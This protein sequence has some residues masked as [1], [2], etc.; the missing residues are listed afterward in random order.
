MFSAYRPCSFFDEPIITSHGIIFGLETNGSYITGQ[1]PSFIQA[2]YI[3][4]NDVPI[5]QHINFD[6]N[7]RYISTNNIT[8]KMIGGT[9]NNPQTTQ[10]NQPTQPAIANSKPDIY[11]ERRQEIALEIAVMK[12]TGLDTK[13]AKDKKE[14]DE[15][16]SKIRELV[17]IAKTEGIEKV[18]YKYIPVSPIGPPPPVK[19]APK[20]AVS[21][22]SS[23]SSSVSR[24]ATSSANSSATSSAT[25]L[26]SVSSGTSVISRDSLKSL[27]KHSL[28]SRIARLA[29][30]FDE[31]SVDFDVVTE[32]ETETDITTN[33]SETSTVTN[34]V[35]KTD[36]HS[37]LIAN[38]SQKQIN[39]AG[40]V[41]IYTDKKGK[42]SLYLGKNSDNLY[43]CIFDEILS[44][45][46]GEKESPIVTATKSVTT[47]FPNTHVIINYD[48]KYT[49]VE[50]EDCKIRSYLIETNK[51]ISTTELNETINNMESVGCDMRLKKIR[52]FPVDNINNN[53][54]ELDNNYIFD[55]NNKKYKITKELK[56]I[57]TSFLESNYF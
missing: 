7:Q 46:K 51:Y 41:I 15:I 30:K 22:T 53:L 10:P 26:S 19:P 5:A 54:G 35:T 36:T 33:K 45:G 40:C 8:P 4:N 1:L 31:E 14:Y 11:E 52:R 44:N 32:A 6:D 27:G 21:D 43:S 12:K 18:T 39:Y 38:T 24:T 37:T 28:K 23:V 20:K 47:Q 50:Q 29:K 25:S 2:A 3:Y 34:T 42:Q 16:C 9:T 13:F 56:Q 48:T 55:E 49:D 17:K 57:I